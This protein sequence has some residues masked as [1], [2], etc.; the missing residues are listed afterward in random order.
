MVEPTLDNTDQIRLAS[1]LAITQKA[2]ERFGV[3]RVAYIPAP[4]GND[5]ISSEQLGIIAK[6]VFANQSIGESTEQ[7]IQIQDETSFQKLIQG[8]KNY[9]NSSDY[10]LVE[11]QL[12]ELE[13]LQVSELEGF[14]EQFQSLKNIPQ[15][16][17]EVERI[18]IDQQVEKDDIDLDLP[19]SAIRGIYFP[20]P[21]IYTEKEQEQ[22]LQL[23]TIQALSST[24]A[25]QAE[26]E[27]PEKLSDQ[28]TIIFNAIQEEKAFASL[29]EQTKTQLENNQFFIEYQEL[30]GHLDQL[31]FNTFKGDY[32]VCL[33]DQRTIPEITQTFK[34]IS[35]EE[36]L[37]L[38][39]Q[40]D[41]EEAIIENSNT[42]TRIKTTDLQDSIQ[43]DLQEIKGELDIGKPIEQKR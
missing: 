31:N 30:I 22:L 18:T 33:E 34:G 40:R 24:L 37:V 1:V 43:N 21:T 27:L 16:L 36:Q 41:N 15:T 39:E 38:L 4:T 9:T 17:D 10:N 14:K 19:I 3:E 5:S 23:E 2:I 7:I 42:I 26:I 6:D 29:I 13:Q 20:T 12:Q 25:K 11:Q 28:T 35:V 8:A 32:E